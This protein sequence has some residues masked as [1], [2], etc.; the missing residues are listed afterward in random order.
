MWHREFGGVSPVNWPE[1]S[2]TQH[3]SPAIPARH[4]E[5]LQAFST[6]VRT[7]R[8]ELHHSHRVGGR[9]HT[10]LFCHTAPW[11]DDPP[12]LGPL[13]FCPRS[14]CS[15]GIIRWAH[16][17]HLSWKLYV[18]VHGFHVHF[19]WVF[20]GVDARA[21]GAARQSAVVLHVVHQT[22]RVPV[23]AAALPAFEAAPL[24]PHWNDREHTDHHRRP[25][26]SSQSSGR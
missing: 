7:S 24:A 13:C 9:F 22:G 6:I 3:R 5:V 11:T 26:P 23:A 8:R 20:G 12:S 1:L 25:A 21:E 17:L 2:T 15:P 19:E 4:T 10:A 18:P 16:R 14:R